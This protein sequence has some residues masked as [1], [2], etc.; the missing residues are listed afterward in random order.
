[1]SRK[2]LLIDYEFCC[3]CHT[4]EIAC[5]KEH[6]YAPETWGITIQQIGPYRY[7]DQDV[8]VYDYLPHPTDL[9]DLCGARVAEGELP[10]C[11]K[12]CQTAC[13]KFG[14]VEELSAELEK[15]PKQ[16]LYVPR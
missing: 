3:G 10:T 1:M 15:K 2:A 11:V 4:C 9:C 8:I 14:T 5:Q 16:V 12:H 13:M 6:G 7:E